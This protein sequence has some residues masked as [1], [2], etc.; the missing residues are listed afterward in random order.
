[1]KC[2]AELRCRVALVGALEQ[3]IDDELQIFVVLVTFTQGSLQ[4]H[5]AHML[6]CLVRLVPNQVITVHVIE[7]KMKKMSIITNIAIQV[8]CKLC[9]ESGS[10]TFRFAA[11]SSL[12][13]FIF[14]CFLIHLL[15]LNGCYVYCLLIWK[16]WF[17]AA[18][19]HNTIRFVRTQT[20]ARQMYVTVNNSHVTFNFL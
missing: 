16:D 1:M 6:S 20:F 9:G 2:N 14:S 18:Y 12:F 19:I 8:N 3:H 4:R 5:Q 13:S 10:V 17:F 11:T 7:N 15:L